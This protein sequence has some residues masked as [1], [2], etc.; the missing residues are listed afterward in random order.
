MFHAQYDDDSTRGQLRRR[1]DVISFEKIQTLAAMTLDRASIRNEFRLI[2]GIDNR[3]YYPQDDQPP[4]RD[5]EDIVWV[6]STPGLYILYCR[7]K[8]Y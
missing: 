4:P 3:R 8:K 1:G 6:T 2:E 7:H 5:P